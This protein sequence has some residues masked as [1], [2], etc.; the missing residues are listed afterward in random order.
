MRLGRRLGFGAAFLGVVVFWALIGG[1]LASLLASLLAAVGLITPMK[2]GGTNWWF[3]YGGA[4]FGLF[5]GVSFV[6]VIG[7]EALEN[8]AY[9]RESHPDT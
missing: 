7:R 9:R 1:V 6:Y 5:C 2:S 8:R 4:G 3:V